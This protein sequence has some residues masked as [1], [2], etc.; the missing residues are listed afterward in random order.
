MKQAAQNWYKELAN[1][2]LRRGFTRSRNDRFLLTRAETEGHT[3]NLVCVDDIIVASR[4]MTVMT[5]VKKALEATFHMEERKRLHW[6]LGLRIGHE[7]GN[8]TVDQEHHIDTMLERLQMDQRKPSRNPADLNL[9]LLTAQNGD[10]EV[11]QRIYRCLVGSILYLAKYMRPDVMFTVNF[12]SRHII[13]P[14]NQHWMCGKRLLRYLQ[15]L[16]GLVENLPTQK[17]LV[18]I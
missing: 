8:V 12:L 6:F 14:T 4:S 18:M 2:L 1:F 9:K 15:G 13:T 16:N 10:E 17:K 11:D 7:E 5:D 3:F